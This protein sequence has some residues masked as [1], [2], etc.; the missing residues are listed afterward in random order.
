MWAVLGESQR[1]DEKENL[2]WEEENR[3]QEFSKK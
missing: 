2:D 1:L 3:G